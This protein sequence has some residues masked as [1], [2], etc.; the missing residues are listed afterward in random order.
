MT[1]TERYRAAFSHVHA[2]AECVQQAIEQAQNLQNDCRDVSKRHPIRRMVILVTAAALLTMT[3]GAELTAGS[4]SNLLAPLYGSAQ[5]ELVNSV[6]YPVDASATVNGYTLTADAVIGDRYNIAVVYTLTREDGQPIPK[7][8]SFSDHSNS[9]FSFN[10]GSGSWHYCKNQELPDNQLQIVEQWTSSDIL[11]FFRN[12]HV[13]FEDLVVWDS[14][15]RESSI[16]AEGIWELSF[17]AR[18]QDTTVNVPADDLTVTD[19]DGTEYQIRKILLSPLGVHM[20][21]KFSPANADSLSDEELRAFHTQPTHDTFTVS[22]QLEDGTDLALEDCNFSSSGAV[23][24]L[25]RRGDYGAFFDQ[26][27]PLEN[28]QAL[29]I[30]GTEVP[31]E[32]S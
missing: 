7:S 19:S 13:T 8:V 28:I 32:I 29:V 5:T 20:D 16:L 14:E 31:V 21:L 1:N 24:A 4:V 26:P 23:D 3:V 18:Y 25:E 15:T 12:L 22:L 11:P 2:P 10:T 30:C 27:I 6:G 9:Y 17:T